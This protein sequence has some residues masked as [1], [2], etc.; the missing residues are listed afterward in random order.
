MLTRLACWTVPLSALH[1]LCRS[2]CAGQVWPLPIHLSNRVLGHEMSLHKGSKEKSGGVTWCKVLQVML[3]PAVQVSKSGQVEDGTSN[4]AYIW[5]LRAGGGGCKLIFP[6]IGDLLA[7]VS[8]RK[9]LAAESGPTPWYLASW[10]ENCVLMHLGVPL[11][12][13]ISM[14]FV[15]NKGPCSV[16]I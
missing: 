10:W 11:P 4:G 15:L 1:W 8:I 16:S 7:W 14:C 2:S 6:L 5:W 9:L 13:V 3:Q 12:F